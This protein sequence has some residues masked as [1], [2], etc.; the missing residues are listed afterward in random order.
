[1]L[2]F[3]TYRYI[4]DKI[5]KIL[6]LVLSMRLLEVEDELHPLKKFWFQTPFALSPLV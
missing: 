1:M 5:I 2:Q 6:V 3:D 4:Y